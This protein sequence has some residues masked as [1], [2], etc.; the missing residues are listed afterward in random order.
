MQ[1]IC[2]QYDITPLIR[3]VYLSNQS[4]LNISGEITMQAPILHEESHY[5]LLLSSIAVFGYPCFDIRQKNGF[6]KQ[7]AIF[8]Y[9]KPANNELL[10]DC[11]TDFMW[12]VNDE[13]LTYQLPA[14]VRI[15]NLRHSDMIAISEGNTYN[16]TYPVEI[17]FYI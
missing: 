1:A 9:E 17:A 16:N 13:T 3:T 15:Q 5:G 2:S 11:V 14:N 12:H 10:S 6:D 4:W 7:L 8:K